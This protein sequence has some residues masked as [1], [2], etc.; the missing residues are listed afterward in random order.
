MMLDDGQAQHF[1]KGGDRRIM[2]CLEEFRL[3]TAGDNK[4]RKKVINSKVRIV[5]FV[6][7][8]L[9]LRGKMSFFTPII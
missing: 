7:Q 6:R 2:R 5:R 4:Y 1:R 8:I 9:F 3:L